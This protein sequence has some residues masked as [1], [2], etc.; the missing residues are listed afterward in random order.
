MMRLLARDKVRMKRHA[1]MRRK[2]LPKVLGIRK[3]VPHGIGLGAQ[4]GMRD[5][6]GLGVRMHVKRPA[7]AQIQTHAYTRQSLIER[8]AKIRETPNALFT[9][10]RFFKRGPK[11]NP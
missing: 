2:R 9:P 8:G 7:S 1:R 10:K 3:G 6:A 5:P 4:S 11:R